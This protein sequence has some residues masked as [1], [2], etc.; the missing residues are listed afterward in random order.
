MQSEQMRKG[1][2]RNKGK[3]HGNRHKDYAR[4]DAERP[5]DDFADDEEPGQHAADEGSGGCSE[6]S[7]SSVKSPHP[8]Q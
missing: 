4:I 2:K 3:A 5:A 7:P 6:E 1:H 8:A